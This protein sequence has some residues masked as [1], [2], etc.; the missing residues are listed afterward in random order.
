[1]PSFKIYPNPA[2]DFFFVEV[3]D[4]SNLTFQYQLTDINGNLI[5]SGYFNK[6][7]NKFDLSQLSNSSYFLVI[8]N[9][10]NGIKK[11][12]QIQKAQ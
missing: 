3:E 5:K 10:E 11:S 1:M 9:R 2:S 7:Q 8:L 6:N 12:F 4:E